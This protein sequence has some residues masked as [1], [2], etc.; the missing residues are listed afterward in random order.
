MGYKNAEFMS[1]GEELS[2]SIWVN[3]V[4][5]FLKSWLLL[6]WW[7]EFWNFAKFEIFAYGCCFTV[8][9]FI[10][11]LKWWLLLVVVIEVIGVVLEGFKIALGLYKFVGNRSD[12]GLASFGFKGMTCKFPY[13]NKIL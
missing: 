6:L 9:K 3:V 10:F 1:K 2:S 4:V 7:W 11:C 5:G 12:V 13:K 8:E